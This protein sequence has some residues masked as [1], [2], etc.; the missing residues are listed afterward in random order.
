[1]I[2]VFVFAACECTYAKSI[3]HPLMSD[4][5]VMVEVGSK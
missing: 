4:I 5:A 3:L 1:M 2:S